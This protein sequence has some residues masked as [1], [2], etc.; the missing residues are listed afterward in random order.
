MR[1][2]C[3][4]MVHNEAVFLPIWARYYAAALGAENLTVL[5]HGSDDGSLSCLPPEV[6][7]VTL[8]RTEFDEYPR[9]AAV[10]AFKTA[11]LQYHD[12]VIYTDCDE[13]IVPDPA[14]YPGGLRQYCEKCPPLVAPI[15]VDVFHA[16]DREGP[17][18]FDRPVLRQ[19]RFCRF[20][21]SKC[22]PLITREP[23]T[24]TIGFHHADRPS[25]IARDVYL[26]HLKTMDRDITLQRLAYTRSMPWSPT[27][28]AKG[29]GGH[30]RFGDEEFLAKYFNAPLAELQGGTDLRFS[31]DDDVDRLVSS[32]IPGKHYSNS[33]FFGKVAKRPKRFRDCF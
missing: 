16:P 6:G 26:F 25:H 19:R 18:D 32:L 24:W 15:G 7:V 28:V 3:F 5:D 31:F 17:L 14:T 9:A 13:I 20:S 4:T 10:N 2:A 1:I 11:L 22:K 12:V 29:V 23:V 33:H 21:S 8:P 30:Q 27:N